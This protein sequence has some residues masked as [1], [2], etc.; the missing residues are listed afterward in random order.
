M[1]DLALDWPVLFFTLGISLLTGLLFGLA[2]ALRVSASNLFDVL[3][4]S[5]RESAVGRRSRVL[6]DPLVAAQVGLTLVLL[7]GATLMARSFIALQHVSLGFTPTNV[8]THFVSAPD[9]RYRVPEQWRAFTEQLLQHAAT[10]PGVTAAALD[11]NIPLSGSAMLFGF[12]IDKHVQAPGERMTSQF[13]VVAGD[14]F[15]ALGQPVLSGRT[16]R[17]ARI[18]HE[19]EDGDHQ[20]DDGAAL[21]AEQQSARRACD[22]ERIFARDRRRRG[23]RETRRPCRR[24][25]A[26]S[27]RAGGAEPVAVHEPHPAHR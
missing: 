27:L 21:L 19:P 24:R 8:L 18:T 9:S 11:V 13:H 17:R 3:R 7:V 15:R 12:T 6:R 22:L 1:E 26:G 5:G 16:V 4:A 10:I 20:R 2:P 14:Y 25:D 23:R